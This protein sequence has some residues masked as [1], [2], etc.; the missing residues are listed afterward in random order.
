MNYNKLRWYLI[1]IAIAFCAYVGY[2]FYDQQFHI[3]NITI[4]EGVGQGSENSAKDIQALEEIFSQPF[5]Y[6]DRGK[7]SYAFVST[8]GKY[9][10]KFFDVR[11]L[12]SG[13]IPLLAPVGKKSCARKL[14]RLMQGYLVAQKYDRDNTGLLFVQLAPDDRYTIIVKV[15][16][17]FGLTHEIDVAKYPFA[18]Q[19]K[20]KPTRE[21][22]TTLLSNGDVLGAITSLKHLI[23]MYVDEYQRGVRD[24]D[25]NIMYN[26][27]FV[28][29]NPIRFDVGRLTFSEENKNPIVYT[30]DLEKVVIGRVGEWL[31]RYFPQY[32][33]EILIELR[34]SISP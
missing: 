9:V 12:R 2:R 14:R 20:A 33:D 19:L 16:D 26:T 18:L 10:L 3:A 4:A 15:I 11:C 21:V 34:K 31:E 5:H 29:D 27:G 23:A 7:Q 17:R 13:A 25:H 1:Y 32:H 30:K 28:G 24:L 8:N 6:L 22:I